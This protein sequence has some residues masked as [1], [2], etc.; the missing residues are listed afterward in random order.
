VE[1]RNWDTSRGVDQL[2]ELI[3]DAASPGRVV[4]RFDSGPDGPRLE[5]TEIE[6]W[7][8]T[9]T[10]TIADV[11]GVLASPALDVALCCDLVYVRPKA[12][13]RLTSV[14]EAPPPGVVW[15]LGR[16]GRAALA[17][18]LLGDGDIEPAEAVR[19]GLAHGV[20]DDGEPLPVASEG[21]VAAVTAARDLMRA[22]TAGDAARTLELATFRWLFASGDPE[23]G[24]QAFLEKRE[25]RFGTG[26]QN[27]G[28]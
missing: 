2:S 5:W 13:L 8:R 21:S 28:E 7:T 27:E 3:R 25:A 18:G 24:A 17:R 16:A 6:P 10:V 23:E 15:A 4:V 9:R 20:V 1:R 22:G 26:A 14:A 19:L 12:R 11:A